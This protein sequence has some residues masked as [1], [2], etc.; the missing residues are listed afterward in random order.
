MADAP[1]VTLV[2]DFAAASDFEKKHTPFITLEAQLDRLLV[3]IEVGHEVPH[4]NGTDH[5]ITFIELYA[6]GAPIARLDLSPV[7]THPKFCVP[8][9]LP[10][11]TVLRA[12]EHCNLHGLWAYEV[13]I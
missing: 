12:V 5:Y 8:V 7:V 13:T 2:A 6:N 10:P 1:A 4:P 11:D 3:N 9:S